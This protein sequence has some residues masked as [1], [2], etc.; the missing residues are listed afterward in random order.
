MGTRAA[1][2]F[3]RLAHPTERFHDWGLI[4]LPPVAP[5]GRPHVDALFGFRVDPAGENTPAR[6]HE[7]VRALAVED[8]EFEVAVERRAGD[9]LPHARLG[10]QPRPA[11]P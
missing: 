4:F 11:P 6:E 10:S 5:V 8:G 7:R 9:R 1:L 3:A 2:R